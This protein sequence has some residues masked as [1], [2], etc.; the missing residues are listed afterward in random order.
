MRSDRHAAFVLVP[1]STMAA[2]RVADDGGASCPGGVAPVA[3][4]DAAPVAGVGAAV[5]PCRPACLACPAAPRRWRA[6][7][8]AVARRQEGAP[9]NL[10]HGRAGQAVA[11][12]RQ[13]GKRSWWIKGHMAGQAAAGPVPPGRRRA[14]GGT[15]STALCRL[16]QTPARGF[17]GACFEFLTLIE[18]DSELRLGRACPRPPPGTACQWA[19]AYRI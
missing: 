1:P 18:T 9:G 16:L 2:R 17:S 13:T 11:V 3:R 8:G 5:G 7:R 12:A 4:Q 10:K 19:A 6:P 15:A 14:G